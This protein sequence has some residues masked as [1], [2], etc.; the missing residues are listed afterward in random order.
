[1]ISFYLYSGQTKV[2]HGLNVAPELATERSIL[3]KEKK[4]KPTVE[5]N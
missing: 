5:G 1:M 4:R 3:Q 2:A